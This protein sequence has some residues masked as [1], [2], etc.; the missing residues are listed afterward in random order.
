MQRIVHVFLLLLLAVVGYSQGITTSSLSGNIVD[1]KNVP[2]VGATVMAVHLPSGSAYAAAV[3]DNGDFNLPGLRVGGPYTITVSMVTYTEYK[4]ENVFLNLGQD[5]VINATLAEEG[6]ALD[7]LVVV[8]ARNSIMNDKKTGA[9]T[10]IGA[11]SIASMPTLSRSIADFTRVAPQSKG[12]SFGGA[13]SRF[14]NLTIDGSIFNNS[15]GLSDIPGGQTNS[16]PISLDAIEQIQINI[17]PYDVREAGFTG[18][19]I[20]AV[21]KSGTNE[22]SGSV[23]FNT[24]NE[25]YVGKKA[26]GADV[27]TQDFDVKQ[28]GFR[29]GGPIIKNKLFFF[30]NGE[31]ER[32]SDPATQFLALR[33]NNAGKPNVSRVKAADLDALKSFLMTKFNY[34]PGAYENYSLD[35]MSNKALAR[36]DYNMSQKS[37]FSL[38][39]NYL[40]SSRDQV[41]SNSGSLQNRSNNGFALNFQNSNYVINNDIHSI[42]GEYNYVGNSFSNKILGGFTA[43][44]DYRTSR[45]GVFPLVDI[46]EGGRN[47][48]TFGYE[49]FTPNNR[50]NTDTW[51]L[52]NN[53]SYYLGKQTLTAG[54]N[55]ESFVFENTFTPTYYG[56][57][58]Y[59][60]LQDFYNDTDDDATNNPKLFRYANTYSNLKDSALPVATTKA[61]QVGLYVQDEIQVNNKFK[62]TAGIRFDVPIFANTALENAEVAGYKFLNE[63]GDSIK[64]STSKLPETGVLISPRLG[65]NYDVTGDRSLQV[66]GG[67]GVFTGRPAFVWLS[68]QVGN[69]GILTGS[70]RED[71]TTGK[72]P[73]SPD[74][75]KY[76]GEPV[77]GKPA[78]SYAIATTDPDFKFPQ[79]WRT[80]LAVDKSLPLDIV[81]TVEFIY[82]KELNNVSYINA[83]Q[84]NPVG[85]LKAGPD[86]RPLYG[87]NNAGNR[88]NGK[89]TDAMVL[90][91]TNAGSG[92]SAT[93]K[94]ERAKSSGVQAMVAYNFS[95]T[96]DLISAGSIAFSSWRDNLAVN[97][98]NRPDLSF[99]NNDL[100]NRF[101]ASLGY[102]KEYVKNL[103][104]QVSIFV[105]SQNQGRFSY[106]VNGDVNSDQLNA[107]D[108][109]FVP[110]KATDLLF[111]DNEITLTDG[112]KKKFTAAEQAT[113]F[114]KF[115]DQDAYLKTR[116]GNFAERNG[117]L[118]PI[119]TNIDLS[120]MQEVIIKLAGKNNKIQL[121]A[122]VFNFGNLISN[123][124]GVGDRIV[125]RAPLQFTK[126]A[127]DGTPTYKFSPVNNELP[128]TTFVSNT[129]LGDVWQAQFG[130][131]YIFN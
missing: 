81:A 49:P 102:R 20:N 116:R 118:M 10:N 51:Q 58:I 48:T 23:F 34:D 94:L 9:S 101:I 68:N 33:D 120:F 106:T 47:L 60:S 93:I 12:L 123:K 126:Y 130:I 90:Y 36:I 96:K 50:L 115:I 38:R 100:R 88:V 40:R 39:Y 76:N 110:A 112:T 24:R 99:S 18:A 44:R 91:N 13:D 107:N 92:Y 35:I 131:R 62:V 41:A 4:A 14:N 31:M 3:R 103:A 77:P 29:L 11:N 119:L 6:V 65:F 63:K 64:L 61:T 30:I 111:E 52:Q 54:V 82:N 127:T 28:S 75:T 109:L 16:T 15:F 74:V 57:F 108:L 46:L 122:D 45:G 67:T 121:R 1:S 128:T 5:F 26:N 124:L 53:F 56:Q 27:I 25:S 104:T 7:E 42:V 17:A 114:D 89:I 105:Q 125:N 37:K 21:T 8:A 22:M 86:K 79:T 70:I 72:F 43:N 117:V 85:T 69:N 113:A 78:S 129:S 87:G 73:F 83:N 80:N 84:K 2:L 95:E 97:G 32:R 71:G 59:S 55:L 19:G 66:R 98:N